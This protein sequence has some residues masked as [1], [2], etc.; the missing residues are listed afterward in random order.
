IRMVVI[1]HDH[2][3]R[4]PVGDGVE[5]RT[6]GA[7]QRSTALSAGQRGRAG[8]QGGK[9][10]TE[11]VIAAR[12]RDAR[13]RGTY[14]CEMRAVA[15][16]TGLSPARDPRPADAPGLAA[17]QPTHGSSRSRPEARGSPARRVAARLAV[18]PPPHGTDRSP[19]A[20]RPLRRG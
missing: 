3:S 20:A 12:W 7:R 8:A 5:P 11:D 14:G 6:S 18:A 15:G 16:L 17:A 2:A 9:H 19:R 1:L 13:G 4:V 10:P